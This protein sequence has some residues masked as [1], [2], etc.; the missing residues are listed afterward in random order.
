MMAKIRLKCYPKAKKLKTFDQYHRDFGTPILS[1][2]LHCG[3]FP[4]YVSDVERT[5][6][7]SG[8]DCPKFHVIPVSGCFLPSDQV[9]RLFSTYPLLFS[10]YRS[11]SR[12]VIIFQNRKLPTLLKF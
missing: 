11:F 12:D 10:T 3:Y 8:R 9:Q 6:A 7:V 4:Y 5:T 1:S 2:S